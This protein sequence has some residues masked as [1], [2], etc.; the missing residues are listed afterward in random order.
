M[1]GHWFSNALFAKVPLIHG[2]KHAS[3][4]TNDKA[5]DYVYPWKSQKQQLKATDVIYP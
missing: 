4:F 1:K 5:F 2:D 3:M